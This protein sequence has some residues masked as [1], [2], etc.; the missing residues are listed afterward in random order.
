MLDREKN[1]LDFCKLY[2]M[3]LVRCCVCNCYLDI[4]KAHGRPG[5][6]HSFCNVH[7]HEYKRQNGIEDSIDISIR[8]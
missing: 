7:L 8:S 4:K 1:D 2:D 6:S 3:I 5:V